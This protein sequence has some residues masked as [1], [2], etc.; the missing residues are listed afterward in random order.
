MAIGVARRGGR[1]SGERALRTPPP[2]QSSSQ[3]RLQTAARRIVRSSVVHA[4]ARKRAC[5][6][7]AWRAAQCDASRKKERP[8]RERVGTLKKKRKTA[9]KYLLNHNGT[10]REIV[11]CTYLSEKAVRKSKLKLNWPIINFRFAPAISP[12]GNFGVSLGFLPYP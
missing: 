10:W 12:S 1:R 7:A 3:P 2:V 8:A 11:P 6:R 9:R 4:R 5:M